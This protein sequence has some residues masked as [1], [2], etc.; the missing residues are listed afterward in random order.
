[1]HTNITNF[2]DECKHRPRFAAAAKDDPAWLG[3]LRGFE[4]VIERAGENKS[5]EAI[6]LVDDIRDIVN[7]PDTHQQRLL[8]IFARMRQFLEQIGYKEPY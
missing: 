2:F 1:M 6:A 3:K 4:C 5:P 7:L 8:A